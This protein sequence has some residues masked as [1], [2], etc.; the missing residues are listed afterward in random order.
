MNIKVARVIRNRD[1]Q[2][3]A[4]SGYRRGLTHRVPI[5]SWAVILGGLIFRCWSR[6]TNANS[7]MAPMAK[8]DG[9]TNKITSRS[10]KTSA[11]Y[12][13]PRMPT[14]CAIPSRADTLP[15]WNFGTWSEMVAM[16][17]ARVAFAPS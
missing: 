2:A 13:P 16:K 1:H 15:R 9:T 3:K 6:S 17:G 4:K 10:E 14:F 7:S 8:I 12:V 11:R 5:H